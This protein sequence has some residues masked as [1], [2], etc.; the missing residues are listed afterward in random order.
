[1]S[2]ARD[3]ILK[4]AKRAATQRGRV[5]VVGVKRGEGIIKK[6]IFNKGLDASNEK[7]GVY[8]E[9]PFYATKEDFKV[10][11]GAFKPSGVNSGTTKSGKPRKQSTKFS[12]KQKRLTMFIPKGYKQIRQLQGLQGAYVDLEYTGS[13]LKSIQLNTSNEQEPVLG[14]YAPKEIEVADKLEERYGVIFSPSQDERNVIID[15]MKA[16]YKLV[17]KEITG[18]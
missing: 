8:S 5:A 3:Y 7:L 11:S 16:E 9:K 14:I 4:L 13:L 18:R 12:S 17:I 2:D 10:K 6:R 15:A 1:M